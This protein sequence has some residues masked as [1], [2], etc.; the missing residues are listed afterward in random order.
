MNNQDIL[1]ASLM[2]IKNYQT[3]E[4]LEIVQN[5][6]SKHVTPQLPFLPF[7]N[8]DEVLQKQYENALLDNNYIDEIH[9][10]NQFFKCGLSLRNSKDIWYFPYE[11]LISISGGTDFEK[12]NIS[13]HGTDKK[14]HILSGTMKS[15]SRTKDLEITITGM[16]FGKQER[17][18]PEDCYPKAQ[19]IRLMD[20]LTAHN[21]IQ[22]FHD[23]LLLLGVTNI[24]IES[25]SFPFTKGENMQ[26]FEI[27]AVS[28]DSNYKLLA[29]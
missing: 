13:R 26:A 16:L 6:L 4:R 11:P 20:F 21:E 7:Q 18:K 19:L 22:I 8:K 2:G 24:A 10:N 15:R 25:F 23:Q 17:G 1:F 12:H 9:P 5:E 28:D 14:G 3:F 27:K 29:E